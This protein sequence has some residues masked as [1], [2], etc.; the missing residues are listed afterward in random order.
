[1]DECKP[2]QTGAVCESVDASPPDPPDIGQQVGHWSGPS[3][4]SLTRRAEATL[5]LPDEKVYGMVET[6]S[7]DQSGRG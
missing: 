5:L 4:T 1:M 7:L 6:S 2:L 3:A